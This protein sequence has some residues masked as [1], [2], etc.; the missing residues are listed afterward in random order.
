MR[1]ADGDFIFYWDNGV[2][3]K[4]VKTNNTGHQMKSGYIKRSLV[5]TGLNWTSTSKWSVGWYYARNFIS[6]NVTSESS[7]YD[8][9][10]HAIYL[11][12]L[13]FTPNDV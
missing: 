7:I 4:M 9:H 8:Y 11:T 2:N 10:F 5:D 6:T 1:L 13:Y 3:R 12:L